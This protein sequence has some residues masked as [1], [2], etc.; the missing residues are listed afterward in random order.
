MQRISYMGVS[1]LRAQKKEHWAN[2]K[3]V[4]AGSSCHSWKRKRWET[5]EPRSME[6]EPWRAE[7]QT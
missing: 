1:R 6:K 4:T 5:A 3:V 2:V 7:A